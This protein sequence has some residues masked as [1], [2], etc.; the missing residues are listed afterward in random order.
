[1]TTETNNTPNVT[2]YMELA[3][4]GDIEAARAYLVEH[5]GEGD[6]IDKDAITAFQKEV[7]EAVAKELA[8]AAE[9]QEEANDAEVPETTTNS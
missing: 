5:F 9:A 2:V 7:D 1:M 8:A 6:N 3:R 4:S